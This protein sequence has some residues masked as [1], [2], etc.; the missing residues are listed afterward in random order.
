MAAGLEGN[1]MDS[2]RRDRIKSVSRVN[3]DAEQKSEEHYKL[4]LD[5]F[6][7]SQEISS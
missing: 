2:M 3:T 7:N 6:E 5:T 1:M 4:T